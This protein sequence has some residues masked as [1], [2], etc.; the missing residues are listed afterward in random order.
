ML[1]RKNSLIIIAVLFLM[2]FNSFGL[3]RSESQLSSSD[4]VLYISPSVIADPTITPPAIVGVNVS[5][6]N[7]TDMAY[8]EFNLTYTPGI[9]YVVELGKQAVQGQIPSMYYEVEDY[10]GYVYV[11]LTYS[12][13]VS[14][15]G[16]ATLLVFNFAVVDYGI[17]TL[18]FQDVVIKDGG[19]NAIPFQTQDG[20]LAIFKHDIAVTDVTA[21]PDET[22]VGRTV[23]MTVRL[24]NYGN[25]P[26]TFTTTIYSDGNNI[27]ALLALD[28]L[29]NET[30]ILAFDWN[31]TGFA[32]SST[33]YSIR[34]EAEI[35]PYETNTTNNVYVDGQVK[36]KLIGDVNGDGKVDINDLIAWDAAYDSKPGDPNWNAQADINGDGIVDNLDGY[37]ILQNYRSSL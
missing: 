23:Q 7:V 12:N 13:P 2:I 37:L 1:K 16:N 6:S 33:P 19:G 15:N 31:T 9:F 21:S 24:Q 30:R 27:T 4:A 25:V 35:L 3:R 8:C 17:T 29:P 11:R 14:V 22:Y 10:L 36:L 26:E 5:I 32:A 20:Y 28:L 18:H 34:A